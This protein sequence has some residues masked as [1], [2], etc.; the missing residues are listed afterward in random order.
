MSGSWLR[1]VLPE[2]K[3]ASIRFLSRAD[4]LDCLRDVDVIAVVK[5]ALADHHAGRT[6]RPGEAYL[7]WENDEGAYSRSIGMPGALLPGHFGMKIINA[8]VSNPARGL[9]RAGGLGLCFD[10]QTARVT[11]A[12]EAGLLSAAR[13]AAVSAIAAEV[14][15]YTAAESIGVIGCGTQARFHLS[16]FLHRWS[17]VRRV[18]LHDHKPEVA[19]GLA[20]WCAERWP[21]IVVTTVDTPAAAMAHADIVV[22]LTTSS[23][24]YVPRAWINQGSLLVNTSLGDLTDEVFLGCHSLYVDDVQLITEN[25]RR[26]LGR[27]IAAGEVAP[28]Y[29]PTRPSITTTLGEMIAGGRTAAPPESGYVVANPFGLGVLDVALYHEVAQRARHEDVGV[30]LSLH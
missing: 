22:F 3:P 24:G 15:G 18:V 19:D 23:M 16:L 28:Q 17:S 27:L 14:T 9:E 12:M 8:S 1:Q 13:T 25:P 2:P 7:A 6:L 4:V 11:T 10:A 5:A 26:P 29:E 30:E 20:E 21:G